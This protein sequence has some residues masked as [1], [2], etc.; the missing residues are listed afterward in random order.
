MFLLLFCISRREK[1]F[2]LFNIDE[3]IRSNDKVKI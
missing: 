2:D 3:V 1:K